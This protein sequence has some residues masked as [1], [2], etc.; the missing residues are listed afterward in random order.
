MDFL[1]LPMEIINL[2]ELTVFMWEA[3]VVCFMGETQLHHLH[4]HLTQALQLV[5]R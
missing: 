3:M 5:L 1:V 2:M 4:H